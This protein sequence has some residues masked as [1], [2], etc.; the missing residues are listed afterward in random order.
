MV[1]KAGME[2]GMTEARVEAGVTESVPLEVAATGC[3][4]GHDRDSEDHDR[5]E[6]ETS[7]LFHIFKALLPASGTSRVVTG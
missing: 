5:G 3:V 2:P 4:D 6:D 1:V 7:K